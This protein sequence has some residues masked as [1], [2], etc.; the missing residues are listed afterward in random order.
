MK[1]I[2]KDNN[3]R[4]N[5]EENESP[6]LFSPPDLVN[7]DGEY[8]G[9]VPAALGIVYRRKNGTADVFDG[10]IQ[11]KSGSVL[12]EDAVDE[13][14]VDLLGFNASELDVLIDDE[15]EDNEDGGE[16]D[17][18]D[19]S[20]VVGVGVE[21]DEL[22]DDDEE[23]GEELGLGQ[24]GL[25]EMR[26]NRRTAAL[27]SVETADFLSR[28]MLET[29]RQQLLTAEEEVQ[30]A[31]EIE[32]GK[33]AADCLEMVGS[34]SD[35]SLSDRSLSDRSL[36][37]AEREGLERLVEQ[38]EAARAYLVRSNTRLVI[39]IAKRY[40]GQ[41]LDFLDLIQEGNIGLLTAVDK[42]DYRRGNRFSTYATWWIRQGITRALANTGRM[43]RIP[44]HQ[45]GNVRKLYRAM[46]DLEQ[47]NGERPEVE[48][49]ARRTELPLGQVRWLLQV[50]R[51][52][53]ALEQ[54]AGDDQD[55]ELADFIEDKE[56]EPPAE[57]VERK[58][59]RDHL[60]EILDELTP[61][62]ASILRL[63]YGLQG[64]DP[65]TLKEVGE[66]F[67]LSRE[68]IRQVEKGALRK[69]RHSR[70]LNEFA[71]VHLN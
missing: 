55:T 27:R 58:L 22:V 52:L 20:M 28:Y 39:S 4:W 49:L 43:I 59:F 37:D 33:E 8:A 38:G 48:E 23:D 30:L 26:R 40:Y 45:T 67:N 42:F 14:D 66:L 2:D 25:E 15:D 7:F 17:V 24:R 68:R 10:G 32:A 41:G 13:E 6:R 65:H 19:L 54:P 21:F 71:A 3:R 62:E 35:R 69:L 11:N 60:E 63:R 50:T 12:V 9:D 29:N 1:W 61:R 46:R 53:L 57:L 31:K 34:L 16:E 47:K 70:H 56:V 44:A 64:A 36:S 51:P 5:N 18:L